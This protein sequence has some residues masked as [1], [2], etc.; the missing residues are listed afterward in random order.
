VHGP[1]RPVR[2]LWNMA[3]WASIGLQELL[4]ADLRP[5][6]VVDLGA[7]PSEHPQICHRNANFT[8]DYDFDNTLVLAK[9]QERAAFHSWAFY[10]TSQSLHSSFDYCG[11]A[12]VANTLRG[13]YRLIQATSLTPYRPKNK[14]VTE[15]PARLSPD[16]AASQ[17]DR[18]K[19]YHDTH[20]N[21]DWTRSEIPP[22]LSAHVKLLREWNWGKTS[23]G[24]I[25]SWSPLLRFMA[26]LIV[27]DPNPVSHPF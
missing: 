3:E 5:S 9:D 24:P 1:L 26:N 2:P 15:F 16:A 22:V 12:W 27:V 14:N 7:T 23:L 17:F 25:N 18:L 4:D 21:H 11:L 10:P 6:F 8:S 13:R 19:S 20:S